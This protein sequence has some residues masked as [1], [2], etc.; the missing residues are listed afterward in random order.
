MNWGILIPWHITTPRIPRS[1][2]RLILRGHRTLRPRRLGLV[3]LAPAQW[4]RIARVKSL[5]IE[6]VPLLKQTSANKTFVC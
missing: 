5:P 6:W 1:Q 2:P 4:M 3:N